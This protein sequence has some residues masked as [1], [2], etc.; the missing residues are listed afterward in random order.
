ML[1]KIG[2]FLT[3]LFIG[4]LPW[5]VIFSVF[6]SERIWIDALRLSK[7]IFLI[8]IVWVGI[9]DIFQRKIRIRLDSI[10]IC[11][12][13]YIFSLLVVS[14]LTHTSILGFIYGLR[15]DGEFLLAF[16]FFRHMMWPWNLHFREWAKVFIL[17]G[18]VMLFL[19]ILIRYVF[20]ETLLMIFWFSGRV[21]VW[22]GS[23]PPPIYHGIPGASV[24]RFQGMLEGPNQMAF[25][26]LTYLGTY[27][28][29]YFRFRKYRFINSVIVLI[30]IFLLSQTYSRSG[31]LGIFLWAFVLIFHIWM[32]KLQTIKSDFSWKKIAWKK[33]G[34][35]VII[36]FFGAFLVLFQF[37]PK[38]T[39][40]ITRKWSTSAH[41]ERM[42]IG[43]LRFLEQ[44]LWHG[45]AQAG[46]AS[47]SIAEVNQDPIPLESLTPEMRHLSDVFLARNADFVFSTEHYYIPESWYIQQLI[48]G[49]VITFFFFVSIFLFL[50]SSLK[51][52]PFMLMAFIGVIV[53]NTFLHSF[54]SMHTSL[55][56]FLILASIL[57]KT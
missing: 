43:Y 38:F 5:S 10:D 12:L 6:G 4:F 36:L 39:E 25:F 14:V 34:A 46:P 50:I 13:L 24:V 47:R 55:A 17:S 45:L 33:I 52:Y 31:L 20:W 27:L 44:P 3:L 2:R 26:L 18:G 16:M 42:Y 53:M 57:K 8:L 48:E 23:G 30:L 7:E 15:Y 11:I 1:Q 56:L 21:S 29:L 28:S 54:E 37:W 49:W 32:G 40:I 41:F 9:L 35:T 22:D 19:S 51:K